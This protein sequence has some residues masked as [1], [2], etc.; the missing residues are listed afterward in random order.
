MADFPELPMTTDK[1]KVLGRGLETLLPPRQVPH[2]PAPA[3]AASPR[4]DGEEGRQIPLAQLDHNP[5][6]TRTS[7]LDAAAL[8]EL[9][10]SIKAVG[11]VQPIVVRSVAG[12]R[13]QVI[14]GER[15]W[16]AS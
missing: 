11:V 4:G 2:A 16:E 9:A 7:S 13:Y 3:A 12:G 10:D 6:Q 15:R 1:R 5:Y 14:A 8:Q